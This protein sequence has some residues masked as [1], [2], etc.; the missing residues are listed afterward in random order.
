L[1]G[2][3]GTGEYIQLYSGSNLTYNND[4]TGCTTSVQ[5]RVKAYNTLTTIVSSYRESESRDVTSC[6]TGCATC[7]N[8]N[9][10]DTCTLGYS[11]K[12]P[13]QIASGNSHTCAVA[14]G[15]AYCWGQNNWG[16]LGSNS[17][18][19]SS[20]PVAVDTSGVLSGKTVAQIA[21]SHQHTCA[22]A[23]GKIYCWGRNPYGQLGNSSTTDSLVPVA[24]DTSGVLNGKTIT[25][26]SSEYQH[27]C[28]LASGKVYCWGWNPYGQLGNN[29][30]TDSLVPVAVDT[31]GVLNGKTVTQIAAGSNRT[32]ALAEGQ[33]YC[34]G[35]GS[36]GQLGNNST[37]DKKVPV[38]VDTSGV[39]SGKTVTQI[40]TGNTHTCAL[41]D[42]KAYCWGYN[43]NGQLGNNSTT[44]SLVPVAVDTSGVLIGKT[45]TQIVAGSNYICVVA[46]GKGYCWGDDQH[47]QL[48][49]N[50][51]TQSLVPVAVDTSGVLSAKTITQIAPGYAH[52]CA[53]DSDGKAYCWGYNANGQLGNNPTTQS[54]IPIASLLTQ[55]CVPN[56]SVSQCNTCSSPDYCSD[57]E[58]GYYANEGSCTLCGDT[59]SGCSTCSSANTCTDCDAGYYLNA[60]SCGTCASLTSNCTSCDGATGVCDTCETGY[61][62]D[63]T[64]C[65]PIPSS[66][67]TITIPAT[68]YTGQ[69][70]TVSWASSTNATGYIL[71]GKC[72]T[73][74]YIQ[75]YSGSNLTYNNDITGCTTS[76]QYRVKAYNTLTTIVSG[77]RESESRD[78]TSCATDCAV[79]SSAGECTAC[80]GD[81]V[82]DETG[83]KDSPFTAPNTHNG[84]NMQDFTMAMCD[85][86]QT[87]SA[88]DY[89][90]VASVMYD[91][92]DGKG[93]EVRKFADGKCWMVDN[94]AYGGEEDGCVTKDTFATPTTNA[95]IQD[96][97]WGYGEC[98]NPA[99]IPNATTPCVDDTVCGYM[100]NWQAVMQS[101]SAYY[102]SSSQFTEPAQGICP[103]GWHVPMGALGGEFVALDIANG[104]DGSNRGCDDSNA[105]CAFWLPG[106]NW[107]GLYSGSWQAAAQNTQGLW[108][109]SS[110]Y[111][112]ATSY[113]LS[114]N[115]YGYYQPQI[116]TNRNYGY[117]VRCIAEGMFVPTI[118]APVAIM[119]PSVVYTGQTVGVSW[120]SSTNATGYILEGKC[121]TG[122]YVELYSGSNLEYNNDITGCNTSVQY[123]V[124]A[125]NTPL[126]L[127]SD[128]TESES[129]DVIDSLYC[130]IEGSS[131]A[132]QTW[133]GCASLATPT[134]DGDYTQGPCLTD[135]RD[136]KVYEVRKFKDGKCWM[137]D[138]LRYGGSTSDSGTV[139]DYCAGRTDFFGDG[140]PSTNANWYASVNGEGTAD[141]LYGD[142]RDPAAGA[143]YMTT[144]G[145]SSNVCLGHAACGYLYNWQ[146]VMQHTSA[147]YGNYYSGPSLIVQGICPSGWSVSTRT[148]YTTLHSSNGSPATGFYQGWQ[149][150][151]WKGVPVYNCDSTGLYNSATMGLLWQGVGY[152]TDNYVGSFSL[153][154]YNVSPQSSVGRNLGVALRCVYEENRP[155]AT[156]TIP[157][158]IYAGQTVTVS[159][160]TVTN[161]N[162]Y[163]LEGKCGTGEYIQLYSGSNLT[164]NNDITGCTTSVQYRVKAYFTSPYNTS[165]YR[166][167]ES[168]DITICDGH[169][170][171]GVCVD[172]IYVSAYCQA[173]GSS[174]T[175][176]NWDGCGIIPAP[177]AL[178]YAQGPCLTDERDGKVSGEFKVLTLR[179]KKLKSLLS[180]YIIL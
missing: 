39:L 168:R 6:A 64:T 164:Y 53:L 141:N 167:S 122:E 162:V 163:I 38:A 24:V 80:S 47:G 67:A 142:C 134:I 30:T 75:L 91:T 158:T 96:Q 48:G 106:G 102:G 174:G 77:Y 88:L 26:I 72:G 57:C 25:Q 97:P 83:C 154:S 78:V 44:E 15:K 95:N 49:N 84:T 160:S 178:G 157:A 110:Q 20:V 127:T 69:S 129:R 148:D 93:Y 108:W 3:C 8:G 40:S 68:I 55:Q 90:L 89:I 16:Q 28:A 1:E 32:C 36:N 146:A 173:Q 104:G 23:D 9:S 119:L 92:R 155:P 7:S 139:S 123:R 159:W 169:L 105:F 147:Y 14:D 56:C 35:H 137:V 31:S 132:M 29:S 101:D 120:A 179:I 149:G 180:M 60:G 54:L 133:E 140:S 128:Y 10:C 12:T 41:A 131:G 2:K 5:Y 109:S 138:N 161:A 114:L 74:E 13:I 100:Y 125:Y 112:G 171:G 87:P 62:L 85:G 165:A 151:S 58:T 63:G 172:D 115:V 46:E 59:I 45:I 107:K 86:Y 135:E 177:E 166:E 152:I 34:W 98:V 113:V 103:T 99:I 73:G 43:G 156:I 42:G 118:T 153:S 144:D 124:K 175:M 37:V 82:L 136:G 61:G 76:V 150:G 19:N 17:T 81:M 121:G 130:E 111:S 145:D 66:P 116:R 79:C 51:T 70:V 27:T 126:S 11:F 65:R 176:Q 170:D 18:T 52:T 22:V 117:A 143:P 33:V 21:A 71:E 4:I 94:L 50:S